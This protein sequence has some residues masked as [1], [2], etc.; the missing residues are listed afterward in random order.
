MDRAGD[1]RDATGGATALA[2]ALAV[3]I[4]VGLTDLAVERTGHMRP[5]PRLHA[6]WRPDPYPP[7]AFG[8]D[9]E[10]QRVR[11]FRVIDHEPVEL[12]P[13]DNAGG[14]FVLTVPK[15]HPCGHGHGV[16]HDAFGA[17]VRVAGGLARVRAAAQSLA[18]AVRF[19]GRVGEAAVGLASGQ[20]GYV[21]RAS[22]H[23]GIERPMCQEVLGCFCRVFDQE[24]SL[25]RV[26][27][28]GFLGSDLW[29]V[30]SRPERL[31]ALGRRAAPRLDP[32]HVNPGGR[33]LHRVVADALPGEVGDTED[34]AGG[35]EAVAAARTHVAQTAAL[36]P[37]ELDG[38]DGLVT[39]EGQVRV[40]HGIVAAA[41]MEEALVHHFA[42]GQVEQAGRLVHE[43]LAHQ[44]DGLTEPEGLLPHD[45]AVVGVQEQGGPLPAEEHLLRAGRVGQPIVPA[46][47]AQP[48]S[49]AVVAVR[50]RALHLPLLCTGHLVQGRHGHGALLGVSPAPLPAFIGERRH[51]IGT[52]DEPVPCGQRFDG[53]A[54]PGL[55][56]PAGSPV[57]AVEAEEQ[58]RVPQSGLDGGHLCVRHGDED[59]V[60]RYGEAVD[61][62][63]AVGPERCTEVD[64][65]Q[66]PAR[67][68]VVH[69][70]LPLDPGVD[71]IGHGGVA[72]D[73][74]RV[75][76]GL[77]PEHAACVGVVGVQPRTELLQR[78]H[79]SGGD[80]RFHSPAVVLVLEEPVAGPVPEPE[81][82]E[83]RAH[84]R[85]VREE[86]AGGV[87]GFMRPI[88]G[89][90]RACRP[91][92][93]ETPGAGS[94]D[95]ARE[96]GVLCGACELRTLVGASSETQGAAERTNRLPEVAERLDR[97]HARVLSAQ[98]QDR[99]QV[100]GEAEAVCLAAER[101]EPFPVFPSVDIALPQGVRFGQIWCHYDQTQL[102]LSEQGVGLA[103]GQ[104]PE[105]H[106][107]PL[108]LRHGRKRGLQGR[109]GRWGR[110]G[111]VVAQD[112]LRW[113]G[114][115]LRHTSQAQESS[116]L[117]SD[118]QA[119]AG[120]DDRG[121]D[122]PRLL[123]PR[124]FRGRG[125]P[126]QFD[127]HDAVSGSSVEAVSGLDEE[128]RVPRQA[129]RH[130]HAQGRVPTE[131]L[132]RVRPLGL[133][134]L[135]DGSRAE[136]VGVEDPGGE[137]IGDV[138]VKDRASV[139][140]GEAF[141]GVVRSLELVELRR[142]ERV[143]RVFSRR[144]PLAADLAEVLQADHA[145]TPDE[146]V[147]AADGHMAV[148]VAVALHEVEQRAVGPV[149]GDRLRATV[150]DDEML[151]GHEEVALRGGAGVVAFVVVD[152]HVVEV[153]QTVVGPD[154]LSG[155]GVQG[156]DEDAD[157]RPHAGAEVDNAVRDDRAPAHG[158]H[159]DQPVVAEHPEVG[160]FPREGLGLPEHAAVVQGQAGEAAVVRAHV[161]L[162]VVQGRRETDRGLGP[163]D[164]TLLPRFQ[165]KGTHAAVDRAA[166]DHGPVHA[167]RLVRIVEL[168][169][170]LVGEGRLVL[171]EL[172]AP[173]GSERVGES[174]RRAGGAAHV[175]AVRRP[176]GVRRAEGSAQAEKQT[177]AKAFHRTSPDQDCRSRLIP[178][179]AA[180]TGLTLPGVKTASNVSS[181]ST[182]Q[183]R[184]R[185]HF[186]DRTH[187]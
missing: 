14:A 155:C 2:D 173:G 125:L 162:P 4:D 20:V 185:P 137:A 19:E 26:H 22:L 38:T 77:P 159:G 68:R 88:R 113:H 60:G 146:G 73:A 64:R 47:N 118:D 29:D 101:F 177:D 79:A 10:T 181:E 32:G 108:A 186:L 142:D 117:Q 75:A 12:R 99:G 157:G 158:P 83:W 25:E 126:R 116:V 45:G 42:R 65:A 174:L 70:A 8:L 127:G 82:S 105:H 62:C 66:F 93:N 140:P 74:A 48:A 85:V 123:S 51:G 175:E 95:R 84:R 114:L 147:F 167:H 56:S 91:R 120:G 39:Q 111:D 35:D 18:V 13:F 33:C 160:P 168:L 67:G 1:V 184:P 172:P 151:S 161:G 9:T 34:A 133:I 28:G 131:R 103:G 7:R 81:R 138:A 71:A 86:G 17:D 23:G 152:A 5:L 153:R 130:A 78:K 178:A 169:S 92:E 54:L 15:L 27:G 156:V 63:G 129:Q 94:G 143:G 40:R 179:S 24:T 109:G 187:L 139:A 58:V 76:A 11:R 107:K 115:G 80:L 49:G 36:P 100:R 122:C 96:G 144:D 149:Q 41:A 171:G 182:P 52:E 176:I 134:V 132:E 89:S 46:A 119:P 165:R 90:L 154:R 57:P 180:R 124:D 141:V 50:E 166:H 97:G 145:V 6:P 43:A 136:V 98:P 121:G 21:V 61:L 55:V 106:E 59:G 102:A 72:C 183:S 110:C 150:G 16:A 170:R 135:G 31:H 163:V 87:A 104:A 37:L 164:P 44:D 69:D 30:R 148:A 128:P 3:Q 53:E 112:L